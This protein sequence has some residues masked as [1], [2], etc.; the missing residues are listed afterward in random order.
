M[1]IGVWS[2]V[3]HDR[4]ERRLSSERSRDFADAPNQLSPMA[5]MPLCSRNNT[6][7]GRL[8]ET[9]SE[10]VSVGK[11]SPCPVRFRNIFSPYARAFISLSMHDNSLGLCLI[12]QYATRDEKREREPGWECERKTFV[13]AFP[14]HRRDDNYHYN[15]VRGRS[16]RL[17]RL[18]FGNKGEKLGELDRVMHRWPFRI[19][20]FILL[21]EFSKIIVTRNGET[22]SSLRFL[23]NYNRD[24]KP[25]A[26][27]QESRENKFCTYMR[28]SLRIRLAR[29]FSYRTWRG[30][31]FDF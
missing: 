25:H 14:E 30:I 29:N 7:S 15:V 24:P 4:S 23:I 21:F 6:R 16:P 31:F 5:P 20:F 1:E 2:T 3:A 26:S 13:K 11:I 19:I 9:S 10:F 27:F 17:Y 12:S 8:R 22:R 28:Y 18:L